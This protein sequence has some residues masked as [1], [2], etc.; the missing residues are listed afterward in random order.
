MA[1]CRAEGHKE[2]LCGLGKPTGG[3]DFTEHGWCFQRNS[4]TAVEATPRE[5][6]IG[7]VYVVLLK[8]SVSVHP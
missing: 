8:G 7:N 4:S 6:I 5:V 1:S 3:L 2:S